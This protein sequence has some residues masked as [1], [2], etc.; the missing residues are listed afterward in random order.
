VRA[1][2]PLHVLAEQPDQP[3]GDRLKDPGDDQDD[4]DATAARQREGRLV[5][6]A[7]QVRKKIFD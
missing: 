3:P 1:G 4:D 6:Q 2:A 7:V 5:I